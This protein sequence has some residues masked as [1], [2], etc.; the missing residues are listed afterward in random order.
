LVNAVKCV[1]F[2]V[3]RVNGIVVDITRA[4]TPPSLFGIDLG[5]RMQTG[6]TILVGCVLVLVVGGFA[7]VQLSGSPSTYGFC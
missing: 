5:L 6:S 7:G 2:V 4:I 3:G 1:P